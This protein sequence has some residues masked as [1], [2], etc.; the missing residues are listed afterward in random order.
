MEEKYSFSRRSLPRL[1]SMNVMLKTNL[2]SSRS[3]DASSL[4]VGCYEDRTDQTK[5]S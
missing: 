3:L 1:N 4:A 5:S 2:R